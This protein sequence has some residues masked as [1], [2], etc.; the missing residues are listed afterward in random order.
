MVVRVWCSGGGD[1]GV[2]TM[3]DRQLLWFWV[4][5]FSFL[6]FFFL[7]VVAGVCGG[8]GVVVV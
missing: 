4:S 6:F 2:A 7:L 5:F 3:V 1:Y 8:G